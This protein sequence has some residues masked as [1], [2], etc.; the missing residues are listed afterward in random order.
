MTAG[1]N[2][3]VRQA[4]KLDDREVVF[5]G[6]SKIDIDYEGFVNDKIETDTFSLEEICEKY[7]FVP[8]MNEVEVPKALQADIQENGWLQLLPGV[9]ECDGFFIARLRKVN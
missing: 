2:N 3:V 4:D 7:G 6:L 1:D 9:H 5:P 8:A